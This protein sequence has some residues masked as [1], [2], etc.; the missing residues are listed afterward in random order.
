MLNAEF[1]AASCRTPYS[2]FR[3][4]YLPL[5]TPHAALRTPHSQTGFTLVE[6]L[7]TALIL[8]I[9]L[10]VLL[11]SL[12]TCLGIMRLARLYDQVEWTLGLG[13]LTYPEPFELSK[14][15]QKDYTVNPDASLTE[16]FTFER[17]VDPKTPAEE[18]KD[19]LFIVRTRVT[20]GEGSE[21]DQG[22]EE[23]VR[24]VWERDK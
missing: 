17:T 18:D 7:L 2:A 14:D 23:L 9:G 22:H 13:E 16:G 24:Y 20:W 19:K 11:S 10:T 3:A 6:V 4:P 21:S 8:A 15:V 12:S 1:A 5:P